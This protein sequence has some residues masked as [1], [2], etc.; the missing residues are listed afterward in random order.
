[1]KNSSN[2]TAMKWGS[3]SA[4]VGIIFWFGLYFTDLYM[5]NSVNWTIY[6][7]VLSCQVL[8]IKEFRDKMNGGFVKFG[9]AFGISFK[10]A[11]LSGIVSSLM[12]YVMSKWID[13]GMTEA[14]KQK[15]MNDMIAKGMSDE[16][17]DKAMNMTSFFFKPEFILIVGII[18]GALIFGSIFSLIISA[19]M[20]KDDTF[21]NIDSNE[22][23]DSFKLN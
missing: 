1:M 23:S 3:I 19:I 5:N 17:I 21:L 2:Q 22:S 4:L 13:T 20:K 7:V 12:G 11:L 18:M 14:I 15:A 6:L 8:G 9:T 10:I 16:M